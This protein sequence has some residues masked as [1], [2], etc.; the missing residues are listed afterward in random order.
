M[1]GRRGPGSVGNKDGAPGYAAQ[2]WLTPRPRVI[3]TADGGVSFQAVGGDG[4]KL[5]APTAT[6]DGDPRK[7]VY[8][9]TGDSETPSL[10]A[11]LVWGPASPTAA[12]ATE[13]FD[14]SFMNGH[15][16]YQGY[17]TAPLSFLY[18]TLARTATHSLPVAVRHP[19][20]PDPR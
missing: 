2:L 20:P 18:A 5:A 13:P 4:L 14:C 12:Y 1:A 19:T 17:E 7:E 9:Y 15:M 16:R 8:R 10:A 6:G 3:A 11:G